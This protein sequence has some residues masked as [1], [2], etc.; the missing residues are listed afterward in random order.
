MLLNVACDA[1]IGE[2]CDGL[3]LSTPLTDIS[4]G[5]SDFGEFLEHG[6]SGIG[7]MIFVSDSFARIDEDVPL[8]ENFLD[9]FPLWEVWEL[10]RAHEPRECMLGV[11]FC[12]MSECFVGVALPFSLEFHSAEAYVGRLHEAQHREA[13]AS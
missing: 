8:L 11:C 10:V 13:V 12:E 3:F 9:I 7:D 4:G 2:G 5:D 1:W 6:E